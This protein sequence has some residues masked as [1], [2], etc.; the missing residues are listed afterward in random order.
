MLIY[1]YLVIIYQVDKARKTPYITY[2][3]KK[4]IF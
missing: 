1:I 3:N 4:L 2:I